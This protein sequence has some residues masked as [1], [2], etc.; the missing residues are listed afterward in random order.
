MKAVQGRGHL[1]GKDTGQV[2][3]GLAE[4]GHGAAQVAQ[5]ME[6]LQRHSQIRL[7][8][9]PLPG[10]GIGEPVAHPERQVGQS[11]LRGEFRECPETMERAGRR[12]ALR[13]I[14]ENLAEPFLHPSGVHGGRRIVFGKRGD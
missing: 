5:T 7:H 4:F 11:D 10:F 6:G 12:R 2:A 8:Q 3:R 9:P 13:N 1:V 14:G